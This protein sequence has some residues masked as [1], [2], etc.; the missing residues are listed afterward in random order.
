M[1]LSFI[2]GFV[3]LGETAEAFTQRGG[4]LEAEV[5]FERGGVSIGDGDIAGLHG[6]EL[7]VRLEIVAFGEHACTY[8]LFLEDGDEV[9]QVLGIVV[10]DVIYFI[11]RDGKTVFSVFLFRGVLHHTDDS[12][13]DV[14]DVGEVALAVAIVEDF[15]GVALH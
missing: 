4:G 3:P 9:E 1:F 10:A 5:L 14:I 2:I 12:F 11:R 8:K 15:N 13:D 7:L 6:H